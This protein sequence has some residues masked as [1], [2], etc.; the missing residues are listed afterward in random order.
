MDAVVTTQPEAL[1]IADGVCKIL[2]EEAKRQLDSLLRR[3]DRLR[4]RTDLR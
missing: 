2:D 4:T 3:P 1:S